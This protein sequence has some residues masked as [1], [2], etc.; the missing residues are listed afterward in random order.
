MSTVAEGSN[1][2]EYLAISAEA[3]GLTGEYFDGVR[4]AQAHAQ[5]YD[6]EARR[7]LRMLSRQLTRFDESDD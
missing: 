7:R 3:D 2:V 4:R 1:A 6:P 5:A